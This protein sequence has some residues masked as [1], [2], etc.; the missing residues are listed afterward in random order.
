[1]IDAECRTGQEK[2]RL[3]ARITD[4]GKGGVCLVSNQIIEIGT[5]LTIKFRLPKIGLIS[6]MN[7][8]VIWT[9]KGDIE[10]QYISGIGFLNYKSPDIARIMN[11]I[12][13][14]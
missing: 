12:D 14:P 13:K 2:S 9:K 4:I 11:C 7:G 6:D 10:G 5:L 8:I 3:L 1:S